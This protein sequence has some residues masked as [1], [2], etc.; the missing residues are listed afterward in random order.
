MA[1]TKQTPIMSG[2]SKAPCKDLATKAA[3]KLVPATTTGGIKKPYCYRPSTV[4]LCEICCYQR[5]IDL[6][7]RK[8]P[9]KRLIEAY[10]ISVLKDAN[11]CAIYRKRVTVQALARCLRGKHS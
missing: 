9:F 1:R 2:A 3:Y 11:L 5:S 6:L 10:T 4:A 7:I 8:L